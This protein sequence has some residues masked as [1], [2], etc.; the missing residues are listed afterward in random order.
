MKAIYLIRKGAAEK[1]FEFRDVAKPVPKENEVVIKVEYSGLNFA[2]TLARRGMY[3]D[4]PPMPCVLGYDVSGIIDA[5]GNKVISLKPGDRVTSFTHFGGYA[6]Y[7]VTNE[8]GAVKIPDSLDGAAATALATQYGTAYY[9]SAEAT[10]M[11]EGDTV[12]IHAAAG[13]VGTALTQYALY[14]KCIVFATAGSDEKI[15]MLKKA[16][17]QYPINYRKEDYKDVIKRNAKGI[18]VIFESLGGKYVKDGIKL[19]NPGGRIICFG[20]AEMSNST[21]PFYQLKTGLAFGFYHPAQF[22]MPSKSIIGVNMLAIADNKPL[23]LKRCLEG[24]MELYNKNIFKPF[25]GKVFPANEVAKA[26]EYIESRASTGKVAI[27][28]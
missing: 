25:A 19:L 23:V 12:L 15:A 11:N 27:R 14:K 10:N 1:A 3:R 17:V 7:A 24:V 22:I 9:C 8:M 13:G 6:E 20:A 28:W 21:N 18:D 4:A 2:D 16:G 5:V 26:H